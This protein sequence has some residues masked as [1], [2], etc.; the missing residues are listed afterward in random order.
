M[1]NVIE[2]KFITNRSVDGRCYWKRG[3]VGGTMVADFW[4]IGNMLNPP[5]MECNRANS[6][7]MSINVDDKDAPRAVWDECGV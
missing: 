2:G 6:D 7:A 4:W 5:V 3:S 1:I